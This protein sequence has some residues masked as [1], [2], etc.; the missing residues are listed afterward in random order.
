MSSDLIEE[1]WVIWACPWPGRIHELLPR[2]VEISLEGCGGRVVDLRW[3]IY[4]GTFVVS[5]EG[6][7]KV[8]IVICKAAVTYFFNIWGTILENDIYLD[9]GQVC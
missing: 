2:L 7:H 4:I 1:P 8:G 3:L 9:A 6:T 5:R